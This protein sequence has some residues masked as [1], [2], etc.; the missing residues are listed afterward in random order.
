MSGNRSRPPW[1]VANP[2]PRGQGKKLRRPPRPPV[3][4]D[5][6]APGPRLAAEWLLE[7][8]DQA[9]RRVGCEPGLEA[10]PGALRR[11]LV[12]AL[13]GEAAELLRSKNDGI[14][15][16]LQGCTVVI[17][18]ARGGPDGAAMPLPPPPR[19]PYSLARFGDAH[20]P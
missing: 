17:E 10:L 20:L 14:P 11:E 15:D 2:A 1:T 4:R 7:R 9:R 18:A 5:C 12:R 19:Y 13:E 8:F 6:G 3:A 16:S